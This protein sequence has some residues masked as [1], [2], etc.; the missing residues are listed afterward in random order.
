MTGHKPLEDLNEELVRG[1]AQAQR[2]EYPLVS[3]TPGPA[4]QHLLDL[5]D[6]PLAPETEGAERPPLPVA[7]RR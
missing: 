5:L 1:A 6:E 7:K 3:S 2:L 4:L